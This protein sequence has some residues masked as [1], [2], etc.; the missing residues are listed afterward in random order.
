MPKENQ[1]PTTNS[2]ELETLIQG[3]WTPEQAQQ[4]IDNQAK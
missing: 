2:S 4:I 3:G 1:T